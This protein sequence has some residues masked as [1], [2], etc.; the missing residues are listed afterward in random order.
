MFCDL[1]SEEEVEKLQKDSWHDLFKDLPSQLRRRW[2]LKIDLDSEDE[3]DIWGINDLNFKETH[4]DGKPFSPADFEKYIVDKRVLITKKTPYHP[5]SPRNVLV[6]WAV[7]EKLVP[8]YLLDKNPY[9]LRKI[10]KRI[11]DNKYIVEQEK[12]EDEEKI[13][14]WVTKV[15]AFLEDMTLK[16][17]IPNITLK[18][19]TG[20]IEVGIYIFEQVNRGGVRLDIYDL[21]VARMAL[22]RKDNGKNVN[23]T[24]EMERLCKQTQ[25]I[26]EAIYHGEKDGFDPRNMGIWNKEDNIPEKI[27]KKVFKNC[28]AICNLK[29]KDGLQNNLSDKYIKENH[30]LQLT[31]KEIYD[32]WEETVLTLFSV[33]QFLHFRCGIVKLKDIPY[34]LLVVP[35]FVFFIKVLD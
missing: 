33:L 18:G 2:C 1:F 26:N 24:T 10:L 23:L 17:V 27:F 8:L 30:L 9:L 32:N 12:E 6:D 29:N 5:D 22:C 21:L 13:D 4:E 3:D 16:T 15:M 19:Q 34:E 28:L 11:V 20:G 35:L 25:S 7:S 14:I 31:D